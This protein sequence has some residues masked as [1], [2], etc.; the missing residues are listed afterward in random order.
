MSDSHNDPPED[1]TDWVALEYEAI[2]DEVDEVDEV[3]AVS[4]NV[5]PPA[6]A[7]PSSPHTPPPGEGPDDS[8]FRTPPQDRKLLPKNTPLS[9]NLS[10]RRHA[11]D[12]TKSEMMHYRRA[13][14]AK[15]WMLGPMP[16]EEFLSTFLP[17]GDIP[18]ESLRNRTMPDPTGAFDN[19]P[20]GT[21]QEE[22]LYGPL[23]CDQSLVRTSLTK[24]S[25]TD[26]SNW[27]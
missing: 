18:E 11:T 16:V 15:K 20:T 8:A 17:E 10:A 12:S 13:E 7:A 2:A 27:P 4:E 19:V 22:R 14:E 25:F 23:V 9:A 5:T 26:R 6:S 3:D 21:G 1:E 24:S